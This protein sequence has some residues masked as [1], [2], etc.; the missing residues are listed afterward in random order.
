[1][2]NILND[3]EEQMPNF[4]KLETWKSLYID[5]E[6]PHV[7]R[8]YLDWDEFRINLHIIHP[9]PTDKEAFYHPHP[10]PS[11]CRILNRSY[12]MKLGYE[13]EPDQVNDVSDLI[14]SEGSVYE[15][16][17]PRAWHSV[18]P[19]GG[20]VTSLMVTGKPWGLIIPNQKGHERKELSKSRVE[21]ILEIFRMFYNEGID[22]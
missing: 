7:E 1:M 18:S 21:S 2:L 17:Q 3:I 5:Y 6:Y 4:L 15:M 11:A 13:F 22:G 10:W 19:I 8:V 12:R 16:V 14:L 20:N 9:I